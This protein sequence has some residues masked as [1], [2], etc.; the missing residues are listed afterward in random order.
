MS[1][2]FSSISIRDLT[3]KNR[4]VMPAMCMNMA[5][6]YGNAKDFHV[7][8]Y[9]TRAIGGVGLI[10]VEATAVEPSGRITSCDLGIWDDS[11][12]DGLKR[13]TRS[14]KKYG[15]SCGIQLAHAGRKCEADEDTIYAPS[16]IAFSSDYKTPVEMTD[17]DM[18]RVINS[19]KNA[20]YRAKICGFDFIE[21]HGAHGY[22]INQFL[23]PLTN[24]RVDEFNG[25]IEAR[26]K[27]LILIINAIR[28]LWD[29]PLGLRISADE[30]QD[31]GNRAEDLVKVVK[32]AK[33]AGVDIIDV[34]TGGVVNVV[35][36]AF[37][38]Y[39]I[40]YA[41]YIK[42]YADIP[43]MAGGLLTEVMHIE[44]ILSN[45]RADMVYIGR[46]LLRNPNFPQ[47]AAYKLNDNI[48]WHKSY[49]RARFR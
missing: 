33:E 43:V 22:L 6:N 1:K 18:T 45:N 42:E 35:P 28:N 40:K 21:I 48:E 44:E 9:A 23:S 27:F 46:E 49:E 47:H 30:F 13:I 16:A 19:F 10:I 2:L 3:I 38:G 5:D 17:N 7:I 4:I 41:E 36:N 29:G 32:L 25:S 39:Q 37:P 26:A 15:A 34:S 20:T 8:H 24:K 14:I 31:E 12:I 11:Q